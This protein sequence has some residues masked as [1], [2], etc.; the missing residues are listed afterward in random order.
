[1]VCNE[2]LHRLV[3]KFRFSFFPQLQSK[4]I[5]TNFWRQ[6]ELWHCPLSLKSHGTISVSSLSQKPSLL[7]ELAGITSRLAQNIM[8]RNESVPFLSC[9]YRINVSSHFENC[10]ENIF[11]SITHP[12]SCLDSL[13]NMPYDLPTQWTLKMRNVMKP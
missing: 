7:S 11:P 12:H 3:S 4:T 6:K 8:G 9:W 13:N 5:L 1:M 10:R 2:V